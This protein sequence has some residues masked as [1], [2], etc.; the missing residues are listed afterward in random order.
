MNLDDKKETTAVEHQDAKQSVDKSRRSFAKVAAAAPVVMTLAGKPVLGANWE[1]R[2]SFSGNMSGNA[3]HPDEGTCEGC[4]PG[5]WKNH[6]SSWPSPYS[7]GTCT[8]QNSGNSDHCQTSGNQPGVYTGGTTFQSVF[9]SLVQRNGVSGSELMSNLLIEVSHSWTLH[10]HAVA[11]LLNAASGIN[12]GNTVSDI[13]GWW[14]DTS[15][16]DEVLKN[17]YAMLNERVCPLP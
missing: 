16:G 7:A 1:V 14:N 12:F 8:S 15:I 2:C 10:A 9:G 5:F 13:V 6:P 11:A 3:S 4:T 17:R